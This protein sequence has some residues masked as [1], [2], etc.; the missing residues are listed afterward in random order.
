MFKYIITLVTIFAAFRLGAISPTEQEKISLIS[1][2]YNSQTRTW[3]TLSWKEVPLIMT[4]ENGHIYAFGLKSSDKA[5]KTIQIGEVT[6]LY[7]EDDQ[8]GLADVQMSPWFEIEGQQAFVYRMGANSRPRNDA[9]VLA[10]ERFHR[11]QME[12]FVPPNKMGISRDHL[13]IENLTWSEI[14]DELFH[15]FLSAKGKEKDEYL[16]DIVAVHSWRRSLLSEDTIAWEDNQMKMEGLADYVGTHLFG[17][18]VA[19]LYMHPE[20]QKDGIVDNAIKWRHYLAGATVGYALDYLGVEGW[21]E[22]IEEGET[23]LSDL[24][25]QAMPMTSTDQQTRLK[26]IKTRFSYA[27]RRKEMSDRVKGYQTELNEL[28]QTYEQ[29]KGVKLYLDH[30]RASISGG[31]S[32]AKLYY[33]ADGSTVGID[34]ESISTTRDGQWKFSTRRTS[35]LF[36]HK[37]GIREIKVSENAHIVLDNVSH[38]LSEVLKKPREYFFNTL[39]IDGKEASFASEG[40]RGKL[41]S[42]GH[43]IRVNFRD[44]K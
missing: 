10:H 23:E 5:W 17:G 24:L 2:H 28:Y 4:F 19:L 3:P 44:R 18:E 13:N 1:R 8:W 9:T 36:Q 33:L 25:F 40:H 14:E 20:N 12:H 11:H 6:A 7:T 26:K 21:K 35:H 42:D 15:L 22:Q 16:A 32:N 39:Q 34:D 31:G 43:S 30:P 37:N 38:S 27:K 41:I 29:Q